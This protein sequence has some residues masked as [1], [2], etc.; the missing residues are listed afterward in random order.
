M[1]KWLTLAKKLEATIPDLTK[2]DSMIDLALSGKFDSRRDGL[3]SADL[4]NVVEILSEINMILTDAN[5]ASKTSYGNNNIK[6]SDKTWDGGKS[7]AK[8]SIKSLMNR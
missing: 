2:L 7:T 6:F 1:Q 3:K 5:S 4:S 8:Y